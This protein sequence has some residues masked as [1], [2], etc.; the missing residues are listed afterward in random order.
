MFTPVQLDIDREADQHERTALPV[1][2]PLWMGD[3]S[4]R[5]G[6]RKTP[7]EC[8]LKLYTPSCPEQEDLS[9]ARVMLLH[10]GDQMIL[11]D[12]NHRY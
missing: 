6:Q 11:F 10:K 9:L 4:Q 7:P 5:K 3:C 1:D 8:L 2:P 12:S